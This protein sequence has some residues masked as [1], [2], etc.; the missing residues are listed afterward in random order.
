MLEE[1]I[2][3]LHHLLTSIEIM[4]LLIEVELK[5]WCQQVLRWA[6]EKFRRSWLKTKKTGHT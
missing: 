5:P 3:F 6:S 4:I 1:T 2:R